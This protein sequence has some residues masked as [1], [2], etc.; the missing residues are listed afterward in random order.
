[1]ARRLEDVLKRSLQEVLKRS[2]K[3]L[4]DV[5]KTYDQDEYINLDQ[6]VLKTFS[7]DEDV[8]KTSSSRRIFA[9]TNADFQI[10]LHV[11]IRIKIIP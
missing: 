8:L 9:G 3:R 7:E 1:M 11:L 4:E 6:D 2:S 10:S 5:L